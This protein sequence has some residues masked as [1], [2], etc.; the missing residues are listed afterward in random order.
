MLG[1]QSGDRDPSNYVISLVFVDAGDRMMDARR[2]E[3]AP[4]N[5]DGDS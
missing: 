4:I 1:Y 5:A 3:P 2:N